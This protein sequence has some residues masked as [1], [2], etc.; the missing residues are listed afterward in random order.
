MGSK[1]AAMT[2]DTQESKILKEIRISEKESEEIIERAMKEQEKIIDAAKKNS[3]KM[4]EEKKEEIGQEQEK[5]LVEFK[6]KIDSIKFLY[7]NKRK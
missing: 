6:E 7:Y 4:L 3:S 2:N 5:K 1:R